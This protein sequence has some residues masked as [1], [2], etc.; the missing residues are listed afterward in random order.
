MFTFKI[1]LKDSTLKNEHL[2]CQL[3]YAPGFIKFYIKMPLLYI[4][5]LQLEVSPEICVPLFIKEQ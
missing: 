4:S 3:N 2:H 1:L 5:Y